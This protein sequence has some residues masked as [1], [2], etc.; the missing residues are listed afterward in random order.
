MNIFMKQGFL[1][2]LRTKLSFSSNFQ[3]HLVQSTANTLIA[4]KSLSVWDLVA[5]L[6]TFA[7][8]CMFEALNGII[9]LTL[10][11]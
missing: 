5:H 6:F 11:F 8:D 1:S 3:P 10:I 2:V 7:L 4:S 9:L